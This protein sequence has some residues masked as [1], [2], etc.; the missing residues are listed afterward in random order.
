M[1]KLNVRFEDTT[2][3]LIESVAEQ[4]KQTFSA[5]AREA[6][7]IGLDAIKHSPAYYVDISKVNEQA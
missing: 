3:D 2:K 5:V 6:M 4:Q 1:E 7:L